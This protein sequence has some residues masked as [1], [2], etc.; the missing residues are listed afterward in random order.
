MKSDDSLGLRVV[1]MLQKVHQD[2]HAIPLKGVLTGK[3][4]RNGLAFKGG[5]RGY[6]TGKGTGVGGEGIGQ[7][8]KFLAIAGLLD[9]PVTV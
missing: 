7:D 8:G 5:K 6:P 1:T 9:V 3:F 4:R 2:F